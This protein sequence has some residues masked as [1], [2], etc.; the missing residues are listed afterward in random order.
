MRY[1]PHTQTFSSPSRVPF[2]IFRQIST[3]IIRAT[4]ILLHLLPPPDSRKP[5]AV[6]DT[7]QL[8]HWGL[9]L[10]L[11]P[12]PGQPFFVN[13]HHDRFLDI[14][15]NR[16]LALVA[17]SLQTL[18]LTGNY[19]QLLL[20]ITLPSL[21]DLT[22]HSLVRMVEKRPKKAC[23]PALKRLH[24]TH[25]RRPDEHNLFSLI[26]RNAPTL[27]ILNLWCP[28]VRQHGIEDS[29]EKPTSLKVVVCPCYQSDTHW[30]G[31]SKSEIDTLA[32]SHE[33][34]IIEG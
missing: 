1:L 13:H 29:L 26:M 17:H 7:G 31:N 19:A 11:P 14:D 25:H 33:I 22:L 15:K 12:N 10:I 30:W 9:V 18:E 2:E 3:A 16:V 32:R 20:P 21:Q 4:H 8:T 24:L 27:E 23:Y 6:D 5:C 34:I 28:L